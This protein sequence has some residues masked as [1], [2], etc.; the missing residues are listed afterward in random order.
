MHDMITGP[1]LVLSCMLCDLL[2][3]K[4]KYQFNVKVVL[5]YQSETDVLNSLGIDLSTL[6]NSVNKDIKVRI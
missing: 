1:Y 2:E 6:L 4:V 5:S 3:H